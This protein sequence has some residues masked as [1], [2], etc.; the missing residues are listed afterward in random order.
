MAEDKLA[1]HIASAA[2]HCGIPVVNVNSPDGN[3]RLEAK[4]FMEGA[5]IVE[6]FDDLGFTIGVV[7]RS[8]RY[9]TAPNVVINFNGVRITES[10]AGQPLSVS[11]GKYNTEIRVDVWCVKELQLVL[12]ARSSLKHNDARDHLLLMCEKKVYEEIA[13][14]KYG[15]HSLPFANYDRAHKEFGI[16][17]GEASNDLQPW[18]FEGHWGSSFAMKD[19]ILV[20][21]ELS[22]SRSLFTLWEECRNKY[23]TKKTKPDYEGYRWYDAMP[24]LTDVITTID[25][26]VFK[27][28]CPF[29]ENMEEVAARDAEGNGGD[30]VLCWVNDMKVEF[31]VSNGDTIVADPDIIVTSEDDTSYVDGIDGGTTSVYLRKSSKDESDAAHNAVEFVNDCMFTPSDDGEAEHYERQAREFKRELTSWFVRFFGTH[32]DSVKYLLE[33]FAAEYPWEARADQYSWTITCSPE[34][35]VP[36]VTSFAPVKSKK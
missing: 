24:R 15:Q 35:S 2:K 28:A 10:L 20:E 3:Q 17:I 8:S 4:S 13:S 30:P 22:G 25:G 19:E 27:E 34:T 31:V 26:Q 14:K 6:K 21:C 16:D 29:Y 7:P 11:L 9:R 12:P 33:E 23:H 5:E 1:H 18:S 36:K 32:A